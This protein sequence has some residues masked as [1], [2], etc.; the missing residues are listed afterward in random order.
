M[1]SDEL[2]K[3]A[4]LRDRGVLDEQEFGKAKARLLAGDSP[5]PVVA[6]LNRLR[7]STG[8]R[9]LGGVCGG[10]AKLTGVESWVWRLLFVVVALFGGAGVV[11]YLLLWLLVPAES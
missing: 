6:E 4:E 5:P 11:A 7:R 1:L 10:I 3:L 9:W 8:D 2:N